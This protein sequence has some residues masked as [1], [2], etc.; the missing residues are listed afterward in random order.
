[1]N[2]SSAEF[3]AFHHSKHHYF[4]HNNI[5]LATISTLR[6]PSLVLVSQL[7]VIYCCISRS[8]LSTIFTDNKN[9]SYHKYAVCHW[10]W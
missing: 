7:S 2:R 4:I 6:P 1:M 3:P 5:S 8:R 9:L 10:Q